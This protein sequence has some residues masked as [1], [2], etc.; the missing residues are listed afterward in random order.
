MR[1]PPKDNA[2]LAEGTQHACDM[3]RAPLQDENINTRYYDDSPVGDIN[4]TVAIRVLD[5][6]IEG[7]NLIPVLEVKLKVEPD[8]TLGQP[9]V[10]SVV[11][12]HSLGCILDGFEEYLKKYCP[13]PDQVLEV[14]RSSLHQ[15]WIGF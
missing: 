8:W 12:V 4:V 6:M 13:A 15:L 2:T 1:S 10:W 3:N 11:Y 5:F 9:D 7:E 14:F